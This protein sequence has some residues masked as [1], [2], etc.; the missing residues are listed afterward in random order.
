MV[1][2]HNAGLI[3][4]EHHSPQG[5]KYNTV[6]SSFLNRENHQNTEEDI[7]CQ[8]ETT[9]LASRKNTLDNDQCETFE[10]AAKRQKIREWQ[11][12]YN[13]E[14]VKQTSQSRK[15][16]FKIDDMIA[17]KIDRV[18]KTS[19]VHLNMLLGKIMEIR[20]NY[21]KIVTP[22]GIIK[23]FISLSKLIPCTSRNVTVD[24]CKEI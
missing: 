15:A 11:S 13:E 10:R 24:Y 1:R 7:K 4:Y 23:G 16:P 14:M 9:E 3:Y 18:D 2:V 6:R 17:I 8:G 5:N 19:P 22:Q 12:Q 20:K 21:A